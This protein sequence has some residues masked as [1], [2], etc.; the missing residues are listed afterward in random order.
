M[1]AL[2]RLRL[3]HAVHVHDD[4]DGGLAQQLAA[5]VRLLY[6]GQWVSPG[7]GAYQNVIAATAAH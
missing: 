4:I 3:A 5:C 7:S 2:R 1:Q 6:V